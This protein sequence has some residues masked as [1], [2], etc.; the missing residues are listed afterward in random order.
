MK[1]QR[2]WFKLEMV[3]YNQP[4]RFINRKIHGQ[5]LTLCFQPRNLSRKLIP[6]PGRKLDAYPC[7][8]HL[9]VPKHHRRI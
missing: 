8:Q 7:N 2:G 1:G 3:D 6:P 9:P 5:R 4:K